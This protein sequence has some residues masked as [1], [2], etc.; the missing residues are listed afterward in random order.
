MTLGSPV[1][2]SAQRAVGHQLHHQVEKSILVTKLIDIHNVGVFQG[3][4]SLGFLQEA[5]PKFGIGRETV[6]HHLDGRRPIEIYM[7]AAKDLSHAA[8]IQRGLDAII[9]EGPPYQIHHVHVMTS[10][11]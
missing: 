3:R 7:H 10:N 6:P 5:L 4:G 8:G 2:E 1:Q 9:P 11:T